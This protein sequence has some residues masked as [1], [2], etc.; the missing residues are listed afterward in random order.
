GGDQ[1][2]GDH[3]HEQEDTGADGG[4]AAEDPTG[5]GERERQRWGTAR[6]HHE[7]EY[8]QARRPGGCDDHTGGQAQVSRE[9]QGSGSSAAITPGGVAVFDRRSGA[10]YSSESERRASP[11]QPSA[12]V[13]RNSALVLT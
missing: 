7:S 10:R 1:P 6:D 8:D 11:G 13:T 12:M 3:G 2:V 4:Q 9:C 5:T